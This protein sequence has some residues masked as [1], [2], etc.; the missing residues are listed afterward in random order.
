MLLHPSS[1]STWCQIKRI[2][3]ALWFL[4]G[5]KRSWGSHPVFLAFQ[6]AL[7][8]AHSSL[9]SWGTLGK[10][11]EWT[12]WDQV[13]TK[14]GG[15][16]HSDQCTDLSSTSLFLPAMVVKSEIFANLIAHLQS[17]A[18][19]LQKHGG[20]YNLAWVPILLVSLPSLR[21]LPNDYTQTGRL[22]HSH[23]S[24]KHMRET[25][26]TLEV[27]Q[28]LHPAKNPGNYSAQAGR[29][30]LLWILEKQRG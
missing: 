16:G 1:K 10:W 8:A 12:R 28:W 26:F 21:A 20:K 30:P 6:D 22:L 2:F 19:L 3:L 14:K 27:K 9:T 29:L 5:E 15:R 7:W 24:D 23:I 4:Q 18:D 11:H 17:W 13:E 25:S